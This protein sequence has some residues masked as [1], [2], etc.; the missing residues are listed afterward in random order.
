MK[1]VNTF[2]CLLF[3]RLV[4]ISRT[5]SRRPW[6]LYT[7]EGGS[8]H[9]SRASR[10]PSSPLSW[11]RWPRPVSRSGQGQRLILHEYNTVPKYSLFIKFFTTDWFS[12]VFDWWHNVPDLDILITKWRKMLNTI[13]V[14]INIDKY[15]SY[16]S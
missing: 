5:R 12:K 13:Y 10:P 2:L 15:H 3:C 6:P 14:L 11:M 4:Q 7:I 1:K 16:T 9:W 8:R